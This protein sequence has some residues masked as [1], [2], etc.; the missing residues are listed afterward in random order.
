MKKAAIITADQ[1]RRR[2]LD[3]L[4]V[5]DIHDEWQNDALKI[6]A[7]EFVED[8]CPQAFN[9]SGQFFNYRLPI[10]CDSKVGLTWAETH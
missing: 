9:A 5:G 7:D 6:H 1:V 8:V 3:I 4:K 2:K 10:D